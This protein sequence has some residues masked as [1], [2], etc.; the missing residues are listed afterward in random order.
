MNPFW[1][2][3]TSEQNEPETANFNPFGDSGDDGVVEEERPPTLVELELVEK[4]VFSAQVSGDD[5]AVVAALNSFKDN[6]KEVFIRSHL[7][8]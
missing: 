1:S 5:P 8:D 6:I 2:E 4:D 3:C 7:D